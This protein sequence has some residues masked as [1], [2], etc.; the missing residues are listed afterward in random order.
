MR[1]TSKSPFH[2]LVEE[3]SEESVELE[4]ESTL[5]L[6]DLATVLEELSLLE[7]DELSLLEEELESPIELGDDSLTSPQYTASYEGPDG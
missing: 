1:G 4:D 6:D 2:A 7:D 3:L 5:E